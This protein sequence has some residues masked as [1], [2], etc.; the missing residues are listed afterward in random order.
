ML[1]QLE[2]INCFVHKRLT[3]NFQ[4]GMTAIVGKNGKGKS[5]ILEMVQ[6]AL[7]GSVALRGIADDYKGL[8]VTLTF[9]VKG[10]EYS[11][12]RS[13]STV[14][15]ISGDADLASGTTDGPAESTALHTPP[16]TRIDSPP[17]STDRKSVV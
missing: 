14:R 17:G 6:Y 13:G 10:I 5:L 3:V 7:W 1:K 16:P 9:E 12:R 4:D 15:L 2:L 8:Q 11:V